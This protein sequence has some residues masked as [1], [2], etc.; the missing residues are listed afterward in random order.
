M[1]IATHKIAS[2]NNSLHNNEANDAN[3]YA[4]KRILNEMPF[5]NKVCTVV[6]DGDIWLLSLISRSIVWF[7]TRQK[8]KQI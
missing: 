4:Y 2:A 1:W 3:R 6:G 8:I 5:T 7:P